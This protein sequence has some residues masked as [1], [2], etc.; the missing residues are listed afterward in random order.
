MR[1]IPTLTTLALISRG[2]VLVSS[3]ITIGINVKLLT[4]TTWAKDL[5]IYII[6]IAAFSV[7]V[8]LAPP[9]PNFV[10]DVFWTLATALCQGFALAIQFTDSPCYKFRPAGPNETSCA[11]YKAATAFAII[12]AI[13]AFASYLLNKTPVPPLQ[14]SLMFPTN[15]SIRISAFTEIKI[16]DAMR[17]RLDST[18]VEVFRPGPSTKNHPV[19]LATIDIPKQKFKGN[20]RVTFTNQT[21]KLGD[22]DE[23]AKLIED[24]AYNPIMKV[25][26]RAKTK[27]HMAG[28]KTRLDVV[29]EVAFPGFNNFRDLQIKHFSIGDRD[30]QGNSVFV[31]IFMGNPTP[32]TIT[33][34][35]VTLSMLAANN[36]IG[37]AT[38]TITNL[39]PGKNTLQIRAALN[40]DALEHDLVNIVREQI[41]YLREG[42][43]KFTATGHSVVYDGQH[44]EYW[45]KAFQAIRINITKS[46]K[47][48]VAL[49]IPGIVVAE[50]G[51]GSV[52][53]RLVDGILNGVKNVDSEHVDGFAEQLGKMIL[54]LLS[55]LGV[56]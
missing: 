30:D 10:Y 53:D 31:E 2:G 27:A 52:V 11:K 25:A 46:L 32:A 14:V 1:L 15:N 9:R 42:N 51:G 34:G 5:L 24:A 55:V 43:L 54:G 26:M 16:P 18:Y 47:D 19:P 44:L 4:D 17:I 3:I 12:Y 48:L 35:E 6:V 28:L 29:K 33:L 21:M 22:V 23:F 20:Q 40:G 36:T 56:I 37:S 38:T 8:C 49:E 41:P 45:E 50:E 39:I 13:P 7:I